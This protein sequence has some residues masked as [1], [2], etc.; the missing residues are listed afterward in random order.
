MFM[1]LRMF[2]LTLHIHV[3]KVQVDLFLLSYLLLLA[4]INNLQCEYSV[5]GRFII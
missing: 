3:G 5:Y 2:I 4:F 1:L